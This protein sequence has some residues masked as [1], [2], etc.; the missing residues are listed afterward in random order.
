MR[1]YYVN[2]NTQSNGEHEVHMEGCSYLP[3]PENRIDLGNHYSC[4]TAVKAARNYY[5][6]S[7][8]C[9]YCCLACHTS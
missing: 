8:G 6:N 5:Y 1:K 4:Q 7:N 3:K 2:K 9:Y